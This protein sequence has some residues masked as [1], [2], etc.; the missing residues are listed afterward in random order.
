[1][2]M[3]SSVRLLGVDG[4]LVAWAGEEESIS[5]AENDPKITSAIA[6]HIWQAYLTNGSPSLSLDGPEFVMLECENGK[7]VMTKVGKLLLCL[8]TNSTA[9]F[10]AVKAK[11]AVISKRLNECLAGE[12]N[13]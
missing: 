7:V 8:Y 13:Y 3:S 2:L 10:G 5:D 9:Q 6:Y 11:A 1:M 12:F 4:S